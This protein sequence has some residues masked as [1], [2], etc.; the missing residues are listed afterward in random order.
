MDDMETLTV[1]VEEELAVVD[2]SRR[3]LVPRA[4]ELMDALPPDLV[5]DIDHELKSCQIETATPVCADMEEL[6]H[7]LLRLRSG[8]AET[9]R[10]IG[11]EI[12]AAGTHPSSS[13]EDQTLTAEASYTDLEGDYQRLTNEQVLFGCH[14]HVGVPDPDLRVAAMDRVR[15][16]LAPLLALTANSPFWEAGD[17]GYASYRY[18]LFSR[19]PTFLTPGRLGSWAAYREMVDTFVAGGVIDSPKRLY[20][21]VRPSGHY[22]TIEF[23]I[24]DVCRTVPEAL[25]VAALCRA[26]VMTAIEAERAGVHQEDIKSESF[27]VAEWQ[28]ARYGMTDDLLDPADGRCRPAADAVGELLDHVDGALRAAG[29]REL[30]HSVVDDVIANGTGAERQRRAATRGA[31]MD[32][33][34]RS[35]EAAPTVD[36][37][38]PPVI[39]VAS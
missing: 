31:G 38:D 20:W 28:A 18:V 17:T 33:L 2:G 32:A 16:W 36:L 34:L 29:D 26:L 8:L 14:V 19:W 35:L 30:V 22:P 39:D 11:C 10:S 21:T 23:R 5:D 4:P 12:L 13:W 9:A 24:A 3:T 27:R 7:H 1:G 25:S 37:T 6:R 15:R